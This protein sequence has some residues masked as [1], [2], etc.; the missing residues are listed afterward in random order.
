MVRVDCVVCREQKTRGT[1]RRENSSKK[2]VNEKV[3]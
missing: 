3:D 2:Q 1:E